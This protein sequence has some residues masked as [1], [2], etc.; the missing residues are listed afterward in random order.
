MT[1]SKL[2]ILALI[3]AG[4][5]LFAGAQD[6]LTADRFLQQVGERYAAMAD[7]EGRLVITTS[8]GTQEGTVLH[9]APNLLRIDF[10]NPAGQV[11]SYDGAT[12]LV[13][14]PE[15]RAIL[16]QTVRAPEEGGAAG[17]AGVATAEG[18]RTLRRNYSAAYEKGPEPVELAGTPERVVRLVLNRKTVAEG[19][20][21]IVLSV[22]ADTKLIRRIEGTTVANETI[23]FDFTAIKTD[24]GIAPSR[25]IYDAP[26][27]ANTYSNFLFKPEE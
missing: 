9:K 22:S 1:R 6:I 2:A 26:N 11:I 24:Q 12:L 16:S 10:S 3:L 5:A 8:R 27:S 4:T 21:T 18:L 17:S 23:V 15:L 13:Y 25:F 20:R 14:V 7:Y 19:F